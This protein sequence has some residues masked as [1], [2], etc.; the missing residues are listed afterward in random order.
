MSED[1]HVAYRPRDFKEM[2]GQGH[3]IKSM[4]KL[5]A[6]DNWPHAV[7]LTGH[8]GSGKTTSARIIAAK[9]GAKDQGI[10]EIDAATNNGIDAMRALQQGLQY[11]GFGKSP[12]KYVIIDECHAL[13]NA[14][15]QSLLKIIEEPPAHVYFAFCT[16][17]PQKVPKT[18]KTRCLD[19][20][21]KPIKVDDLCD[22]IEDVADAEK[23]KLPDGAVSLIARAADGSPRSAL[24]GL[25]KC[26][27]CKTR[28]DVSECLE[29][30]GE[31]SEII[32]L[33]RELVA[34]KLTWKKFIATWQKLD[35]PNPESVRLMVINYIAKV[36]AGT[37]GEDKAGYLL[38]VIDAFST[39]CNQSE[40]SAP[41][42]L[43][44]GRVILGD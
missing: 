32:D 8:S 18:I 16:T 21:F 9:V 25:A 43:A 14:A 29:Q 30:V 35:S 13:S 41:I 17:E 24:T 37:Q 23:I 10:I 12:I 36:L 28:T 3:I 38:S 44:F 34:N 33:C 42:L 27:G 7:L 2:V 26:A 22:L 31:N 1:L 15:W 40:K 19:Y 5:E 20:N 11:K 4:Q 39:P 6:D